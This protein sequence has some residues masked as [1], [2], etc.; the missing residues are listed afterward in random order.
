MA[1]ISATI[2][3]M[4]KLEK[5]IPKRPN[6]IQQLEGLH[7][8]CKQAGKHFLFA[9]TAG[10]I[11]A[12]TSI[13]LCL[14]TE[15]SYGTFQQHEWLLWAL[16]VFGLASLAIYKVFMLSLT[17]T[18]HTVIEKM[19]NDEPISPLLAPGILLG[20][21]LSM[22]GGGSVGRES[23]ALHM[24]ASI[25][26]LVARPFKLESVYGKN[27]RKG[28][29][30]AGYVA[31]LGMAATFSALFF[32]P[33]GAAMF[34][35]ELARFKRSI[36]KHFLSIA[37][38][39]FV[40]YFV[41]SVFG[42]GDL[43]TKVNVPAVTWG[44][45][46]QC[47]VVGVAAALVGTI[48]DSLIHWVQ[49]LT[50]R[51]SKNYFVWVVVGGVLFAL[52]VHFG[53]LMDF[54]GSGGNT[55]NLALEGKYD[56][57]GFVIKLVLTLICLGFWFKGGEIMPSFCMGGLLGA[58]CTIMTGGNAEFGAAIGLVAFL[59]AFS[60]CPLTAFLM[61]CEMF[62]WALAPFFVISIA[63]AYMFG[64]PVGMY[65]AGMDQFIRTG[66]RSKLQQKADAALDN[67]TPGKIE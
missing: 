55:L 59:T 43:V 58:T 53:G 2:L 63:V 46:G 57:W 51:I 38:A 20:T 29:S 7:F 26:T 1:T 49:D 25:G 65:G 31:A 21:C 35:L 22:L 27:E 9:A 39:C 48:F 41:A 33:L 44:I 8:S 67:L 34:V 37:F 13:V 14:A 30:M 18:T 15:L 28:E 17:T 42:I 16:P 23:G 32:A 60:R 50:T 11:A 40:A 36:A 56:P 54:T 62:G 3:H 47:V 61:G 19:R 4:E 6:Q 5:N 12:F 10:V 45:V 24:G 66:S 52:L 64:Y